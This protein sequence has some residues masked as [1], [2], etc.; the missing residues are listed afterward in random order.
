VDLRRGLDD[1][2]A[3]SSL[4]YAI[5][6]RRI[7]PQAPTAPTAVIRFTSLADLPNP[8]TPLIGREEEIAGAVSLLLQPS[9]RLIT[10]TGPGGAGKTR[11][12]LGIAR[13]S[14]DSFEDG[15]AF[16]SLAPVTDPQLVPSSIA[17]GLGIKE[18]TGQ[19]VMETLGA[20]LR[21]KQMLLVLDN[22]E[23][24]V[25]GAP[26]IASLSR[27]CPGLKVMATSRAAL[28]LSRS[29]LTKG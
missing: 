20:Y 5:T 9:N 24:V 2:D 28:R 23:Q 16:V 17:D 1:P 27:I 11:L 21:D 29:L 4:L 15:V 14:V 13:A 10:L 6:G 12:A 22:F 25:A 7:G 26:N 19:T 3:W 8:P 18:V